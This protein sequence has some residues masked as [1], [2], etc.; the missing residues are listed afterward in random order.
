[1]KV[2]PKAPTVEFGLVTQID[3]YSELYIVL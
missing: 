3:L 2:H 1:M